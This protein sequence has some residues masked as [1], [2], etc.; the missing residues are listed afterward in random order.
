MGKGSRRWR[1]EE[2]RWS[3][4]EGRDEWVRARKGT[5]VAGSKGER[6]YSGKPTRGRVRGRLRQSRR[7]ERLEVERLKGESTIGRAALRMK[8][9]GSAA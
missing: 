8:K 3:A 4:R 7:E 2:R 9:E 1:K 5:K 6:C